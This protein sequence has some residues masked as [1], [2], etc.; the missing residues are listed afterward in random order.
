L[1]VKRE[2]TI[3]AAGFILGLVLQHTTPE[4]QVALFCGER[5]DRFVGAL[6]SKLLCLENGWL[7]D[8]AFSIRFG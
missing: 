4:A 7:L 1:Q 6:W 2:D 5:D 8:L 3:E